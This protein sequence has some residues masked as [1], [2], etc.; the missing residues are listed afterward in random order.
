MGKGSADLVDPGEHFGRLGRI[1]VEHPDVVDRAL[2]AAFRTRAVVG[3]HAD[4]GVVELTTFP[5]EGE[6][7]ADLLVRMGQEASEAFHEA[8]GDR[9]VPGAERVPG[10]HPVR[11][12]RQDGRVGEQAGGQLAREHLLAP[13]VPAEVEAAAVPLEPALRRLMRGVARPGGEIQEERP[14]RVDGAQVAKELDSAVGEILGEVI[15]VLDRPGWLDAVIV[16]VERGH[17]LARL[18]AVEAV[19]AVEPAC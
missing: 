8:G 1:E 18:A 15:T 19:P 7:P 3:D 5:Q 14:V 17:E 10:G 13:G 2:R 12:R 16:V 4:D 6:H 9:P 11:A